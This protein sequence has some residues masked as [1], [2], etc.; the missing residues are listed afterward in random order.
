MTTLRE[1]MIED[2]QL[3]GVSANTQLAY[4]RAARQL[5]E[6]HRKPL[7]ESI[8]KNCANTACT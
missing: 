7:I 1:R 2:L 4:L 8:K 6:Y 3:R 5:S